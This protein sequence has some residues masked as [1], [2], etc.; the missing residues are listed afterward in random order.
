MSQR[1]SDILTVGRWICVTTLT[2]AGADLL[3]APPAEAGEEVPVAGG[4]ARGDQPV[5]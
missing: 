1:K 2:V 4:E 3:S 5:V